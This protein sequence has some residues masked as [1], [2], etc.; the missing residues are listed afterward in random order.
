MKDMTGL[1]FHS[2]I[3]LLRPSGLI[4]HLLYWVRGRVLQRRWAGRRNAVI[5]G[6]D[7]PETRSL[8]CLQVR[9]I[10]QASGGD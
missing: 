9:L 1:C 6:S 4:S 5:R 2:I 3:I 7:T 10:L 8:S